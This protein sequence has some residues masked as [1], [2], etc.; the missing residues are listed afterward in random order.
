M[1]PRGA[2]SSGSGGGGHMG[3]Q[4]ALPGAPPFMHAPHL[5]PHALPRGLSA[6]QL[7][8]LEVRGAVP[9]GSHAGCQEVQVAMLHV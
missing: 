1:R 9:G 6:E 4:H 3:A 5:P 8:M 7:A 2:R